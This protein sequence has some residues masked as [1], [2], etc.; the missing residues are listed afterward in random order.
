[1]PWNNMGLYNDLTV[2]RNLDSIVDDVKCLQQSFITQLWENNT[3]ITEMIKK[4]Y[5]V[6]CYEKVWKKLAN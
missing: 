3:W 5:K 1:M 6:L 4:W 2:T